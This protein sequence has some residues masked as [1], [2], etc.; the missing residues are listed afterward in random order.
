[1]GGWKGSKITHTKPHTHTYGFE[2][3]PQLLLL[4]LLLLPH[5]FPPLHLSPPLPQ[6]SSTQVGDNVGLLVGLPSQ[7]TLS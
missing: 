5:W 7:Q 4:L 1:L 6:A 2:L 3:E